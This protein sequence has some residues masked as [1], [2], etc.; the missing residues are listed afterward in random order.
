MKYI[1]HRRLKDTVICGAVNIPA[2]T[3]AESQNGRIFCNGKLICLETSEIAHQYFA[4][5]E[6]GDG[7]LR[8]KLT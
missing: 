2:Q 3:E 6:S 7:M 8:G 4:E 1:V 5:N